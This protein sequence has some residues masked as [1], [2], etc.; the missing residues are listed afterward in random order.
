MEGITATDMLDYQMPRGDDLSRVGTEAHF[1]GQYLPWDSNENAMIAARHGMKR[2]AGY[3]PCYANWWD[4]ENLDNAQT[5]L[6]DYFMF[7]KYGFG[8]GCQQ[9]SVDVRSGLIDRDVAMKWLEKHEGAFPF[10]Y[11]GVPVEDVLD[12]IGMSREQLEKLANQFSE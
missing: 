3:P 11:G 10:V 1:L 7:R 2:N 12:R 6:H 8:R 9:I 5:G 4:H